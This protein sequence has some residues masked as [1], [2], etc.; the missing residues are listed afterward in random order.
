MLY[1]LSSACKAGVVSQTAGIFIFFT[2]YSRVGV[3]QVAEVYSKKRGNATEIGMGEGQ[4]K[5]NGKLR[6]AEWG[7]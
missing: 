5:K 3:V 4:V 2:P 1:C 6:V 7:G